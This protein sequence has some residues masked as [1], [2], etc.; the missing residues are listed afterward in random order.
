MKKA[1]LSSTFWAVDKINIASKFNNV[2]ILSTPVK[3]DIDEEIPEEVV[4]EGQI[5]Q[6]REVSHFEIS[7]TTPS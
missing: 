7:E 1:I 2:K 4:E 6:Q 5:L 3:S